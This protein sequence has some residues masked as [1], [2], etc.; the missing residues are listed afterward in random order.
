MALVLK[1]RVKET[2]T[3]AGTGSVTLL[4]A[5]QGYQG[6]SAIGD[7]NTTYY[8]IAGVAEWEVGIGTYSGGVL[9]RD[10]V[11]SSSAGG[12]KVGFSSG[13]KDVFV[14]YAAGKAFS[15]DS[16]AALPVVL[17]TSTASPNGTINVASLT[18]NTTSV[19]GD[20]ALD[21]K[22]AGALITAIPDN[23]STGGNKR[24]QSA[25]D[26]QLSRTSAGQVASGLY[27]GILSGY[28]N[29]SSGQSA[30]VAGGQQNT[31]SGNW[32]S[33]GGGNVNTSNANFATVSGGQNN[34]SSA[35]NA[36]IGG[37]YLNGASGSYSLVAG[38]RENAAA[39]LSSSVVGGEQNS[40]NASASY[41]A[42]G[43]GLTNNASASGLYGAIAGGR[44]NATNANYAAIGGGQGNTA[45]GSHSTIAGGQSN[46]A[47]AI[48]SGILSGLS[49]TASAAYSGVGNGTSNVASGVSS[50]VA[51]SSN[52]ASASFS[53]ALGGSNNT[54]NSPFSIVLGGQFGTTRGL[55]GFFVIPASSAPIDT[56]AGVTQSGVL[57][58]GVQTTNATPTVLR[59]NV[60]VAG[61]TNQLALANNSAI[62]VFGHVI[63]N[64]T[65]AGDTASWTITATIK[66]GANAGTTTLVGSTITAQHANAGASSWNVTVA[67]DT[68]NGCLAVTVTGQASTTIRWVC[69]IETTEV[70]Y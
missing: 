11:L 66:R 31:A 1:D 50:F 59:S 8:T 42:I 29:T 24:G 3:T 44:S 33:V 37:G 67:A 40:I 45:S 12:A 18:A 39:A 34:V 9:S 27:S 13:V 7:G 54:A 36:F 14:T 55:D 61:T 41:A 4:G 65:A 60:N 68:V 21:P 38:G 16:L 17:A 15:T 19:S 10:T 6:F 26:L 49:N 2:T 22:G 25:V 35:A 58:L 56:V 47:S 62:Y 46:T 70:S 28:R 5:V 23:T 43:G 48:N 30:V 64:V 63:A 51:G 57:L 20:L 32:A 53:V 52:T 69:R